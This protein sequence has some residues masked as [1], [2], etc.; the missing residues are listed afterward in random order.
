M[1]DD[2]GKELGQ[3]VTKAPEFKR[4]AVTVMPKP[5]FGVVTTTAIMGHERQG[6]SHAREVVAK[7]RKEK[8]EFKLPEGMSQKVGPDGQTVLEY[9]ADMG[10]NFL[11]GLGR[12]V[13]RIA[14]AF[15]K[16]PYDA[17]RLEW[18][19]YLHLA[20]NVPKE[21]RARTDLG[22]VG[23]LMRFSWVGEGVYMVRQAAALFLE[24]VPLREASFFA[25]IRR[26]LREEGGDF[27]D[28]RRDLAFR[29]LDALMGLRYF[30]EPA[31]SGGG[32]SDYMG[33]IR[34]VS[35]S[36]KDWLKI[37]EGSK[38]MR[39][40]LSMMKNLRVG[41]DI[42]KYHDKTE[43][44]FMK[45]EDKGALRSEDINVFYR[46]LGVL[47]PLDAAW[48]LVGLYSKQLKW[49]IL[50]DG[51]VRLDA[52]ENFKRLKALDFMNG[53]P[54]AEVPI[55]RGASGPASLVIRDLYDSSD[56][57]VRNIVSYVNQLRFPQ[58]RLYYL[59]SFRM[60]TGSPTLV[61]N[62]TYIK[63]MGV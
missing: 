48:M 9:S 7:V 57:V 4:S 24:R 35:S 40:R 3:T 37:G 61:G 38:R 13:R 36:P 44:L 56:Y 49:N 34:E 19:D 25:E 32:G 53:L 55:R 10:A 1:P 18:G 14:G 63:D 46:F 8:D 60:A 11:P 41:L 39:E 23:W 62:T 29:M 17:R 31:G 30:D 12:I 2:V 27:N 22:L 51:S 21:I 42:L 45:R 20:T 59:G 54:D 16:D 28:G 6:L 33:G 26:R 47:G 50:V 15:K 43:K 58:A 52:N 5:E